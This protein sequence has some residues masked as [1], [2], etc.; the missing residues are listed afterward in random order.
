M[1]IKTKDKKE[2]DITSYENEEVTKQIEF[3]MATQEVI[4]DLKSC[5]SKIIIC[6]KNKDIKEA[7]Q[8]MKNELEIQRI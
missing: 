1:R 2:L 6:T 8:S 4:E 3:V 5:Q 7:I